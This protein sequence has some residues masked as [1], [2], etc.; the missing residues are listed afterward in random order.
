VSLSSL[1]GYPRIV[2]SGSVQGLKP[3]FH[4]VILGYCRADAAAEVL[5]LL[6]AVDREIYARQVDVPELACPYTSRPWTAADPVSIKLAEK[7]QLTAVA[8]SLGD[9]A[10]PG[11]ESGGVTLVLR[12]AAGKI[13]D[14]Q[15]TAYGCFSHEVERDRTRLRVRSKC[16]AGMCDI[17]AV[18]SGIEEVTWTVE[19]EEAIAVK[20]VRKV[21][22]E[23]HRCD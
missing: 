5:P 1:K 11:N 23:K 22:L 2:E 21:V 9:F 20:Q 3:G 19:A 14:A 8:F 16:V 13:L 4:P 7:R 17:A 12:D 6:Q 18:P 10:S 15:Y